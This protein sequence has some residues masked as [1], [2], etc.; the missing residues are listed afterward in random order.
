MSRSNRPLTVL[1]ERR[2]PGPKRWNGVIVNS[3]LGGGPAGTAQVGH[4]MLANL[5][6]AILTKLQMVLTIGMDRSRES[7]KIY[8]EVHRSRR[9]PSPSQA[10]KK[11]DLR[12]PNSARILRVRSASY[13]DAGLEGEEAADRSG[14]GI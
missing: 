10:R 12:I 1:F 3:S 8:R 7:E 4:L 6:E 13:R 14:T 11:A 9:A 2:T 5:L